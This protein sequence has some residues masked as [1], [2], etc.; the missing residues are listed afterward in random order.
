MFRLCE[1]SK[2]SKWIFHG[3]VTKCLKAELTER[4]RPLCSTLLIAPVSGKLLFMLLRKRIICGTLTNEV[5]CTRITPIQGNAAN[6][7]DSGKRIQEISTT[8][9]DLT[10]KETLCLNFSDGMR[11]EMHTIEYVRMEQ[12]FPISASYKFGIPLITT[13][14]I[15][16]CAGAEEYCSVDDYKYNTENRNC[17][18]NYVCYRT[19]HAHQSSGGCLM[20]SKSEVCCEVAIEPYEGKTYTAVKLTQPDTVIILRHRIYER[21]SNRWTEAASEEFEAVLE[22]RTTTGR[23]MREMLSGMYYFSNDN[24]VLMMGIRLNEPTESDI[25]KLGQRYL[26]RYNAEYFITYGDHITDLDLGHP[27]DEQN[28]IEKAEILT[29]NRAVRIIH[30]EGTVIHVIVSSGTRPIIIRHASHLL[31]FNGTI[32]MD[33]QSNRFLNLTILGGKGTLIGYVHRFADKSSTDWSFSIEIGTATRTKFIATISGIPPGI[34]SDRYI[35]LQPA[36]DANAEQCKWL[37]YEASP[38]RERHMAHRWQVGIGNCPGCNERGIENF[39]LKL[40]PREWFDGLNSTTE[41]VTCA[42]EIALI[43]SIHYTVPY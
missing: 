42:L 33:E 3:Y 31:T 23:V 32:R 39:L 26:T 13:A 19:Y 4:Y 17:T 20:S 5:H 37:K 36:G 21:V 28:W 15:C 30:A 10:L 25:H 11:V 38:L 9:A 24:R 29:D 40:D 27:V 22:I 12:Q 6:M 18:K 8:V 2:L 43:I 34:T 41:A 16:D 1:L 35:C 7:D 14:C